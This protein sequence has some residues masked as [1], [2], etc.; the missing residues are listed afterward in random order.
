MTPTLVQTL[1]P[2]RRRP[3]PAVPRRQRLRLDRRRGASFAVLDAFAEAGGTFIDTA[4][5]YS[6]W[7]PGHTGGE[8]ERVLGRWMA[9][10]GNRDELVLAT[11]VGSLPG[12]EGL[13][14]DTVAAAARGVA[15]AAADRPDRPLLRAPRRPGHAARGDARRR[16]TRSSAT[17]KVRQVAA[18]NYSA[19]R[20]AQALAVQDREGLARYVALQPQYNLLERAYED[21]LAPLL[22]REGL[23]CLPYSA[24]ASGFL[25]GKYRD[26]ADVDSPRAPGAA[27]V[28]R[29][30]RPGGAGRPGEVA[31]GA[32]DDPRRRRAR[33]ARGPADRGRA[34]RQRP[35][36]PSSWP[37]SCRPSTCA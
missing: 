28:P 14:A 22:A 1:H 30:P 31:A 6:A 32:R 26:G 27:T 21:E 25:T 37:R 24:L 13:A 7:V 33:L 3:D 23:A 29:R 10:R 11:K 12:R 16:S 18:S 4:D 5:A 36:R 20:L 34:A 17:G 8:S 15:G 35:L 9:A 2:A 19:E